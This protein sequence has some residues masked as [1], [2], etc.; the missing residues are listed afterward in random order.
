M[1]P[2][3]LDRREFMAAA[4]AAGLGQ[5][6]LPN[7]A[8]AAVT[9]TSNY[10]YEIVRSDEE[11]TKLLDPDTYKILRGGDTEWPKTSDLWDDYREGTFTCAGCALKI[12]D[13][14]YRLSLIHI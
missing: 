8:N 4:V 12:Y 5:S 2:N 9:S 11:W 10:A 1:G 13:S 14:E 6:V 7:T 3:K